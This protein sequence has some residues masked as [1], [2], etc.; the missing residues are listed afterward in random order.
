MLAAR[1]VETFL[2]LVE[3][4]RS[5]QPLFASYIFCLVADGRWLA[6]ATCFGVHSIIRFGDMPARVPSREI[7]ALRSRM[8]DRGII[9]LA[10]APPARVFKRGDK[11]RILAGQFASFDAI[12]SG[13]SNRARE[14]VLVNMLGATRQVPVARHLVA[15]R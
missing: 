11:V 9:A 4:R 15:A 1:G 14:I 10:P 7:E 13:I 6:I 8:N 12:H 3:T 2:P 5:V